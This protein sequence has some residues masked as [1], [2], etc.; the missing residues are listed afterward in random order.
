MKGSGRD[1]G[2]A[3]LT[4]TGLRSR[5]TSSFSCSPSSLSRRA[6]ITS[7]GDFTAAPPTRWIT[8]PDCRPLSSS[9]LLI[10][11]TPSLLPK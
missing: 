1:F 7:R 10:T 3:M 4:A 6:R 11:S 9:P 5:S 2:T 8:S